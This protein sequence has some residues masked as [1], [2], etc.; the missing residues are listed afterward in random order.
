MRKVL[1]TCVERGLAPASQ[2]W[3]SGALR[4]QAPEFLALNQNALV[5]GSNSGNW[6]MILAMSM[7]VDRILSRA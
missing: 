5:P 7:R 3:G 2:R 4:L 6:D 1:W